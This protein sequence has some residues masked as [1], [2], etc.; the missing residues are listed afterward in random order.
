DYYG[1][2][3]HRVDPIDATAI[4][5]LQWLADRHQ[6]LDFTEVATECGGAWRLAQAVAAREA[7]E[8]FDFIHCSDIGLTSLFV[9]K[10]RRPV[11]TRCSWSRDLYR[12]VDAA[13]W[14]PGGWPVGGLR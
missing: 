4:R 5:P 1:V 6:L 3:V 10:E 8:P 2:P 9:R 7:E 12:D 11:V 14:T 13:P